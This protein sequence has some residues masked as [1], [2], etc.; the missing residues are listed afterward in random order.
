LELYIPGVRNLDSISYNL[1]AGIVPV[2]IDRVITLT[3]P[4]IFTSVAYHFE[5]MKSLSS[6]QLK[7]S[8]W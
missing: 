2:L 7:V 8:E 6:I 5:K 1:V 3:L 4:K